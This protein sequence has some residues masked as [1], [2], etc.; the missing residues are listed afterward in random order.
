MV[1]MGIMQLPVGRLI[2]WH[3]RTGV[4]SHYA[5]MNRILPTV[6]LCEDILCF[7]NSSVI[8]MQS[9]VIWTLPW[10]HCLCFWG[11]HFISPCKREDVLFLNGAQT[12]LST[13]ISDFREDWV[14]SLFSDHAVRILDW[15]ISGNPQDTD[16][17]C[18]QDWS[19]Q[20]SP[21]LPFFIACCA[22][23]S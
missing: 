14:H 18:Q 13:L 10:I 8:P 7:G 2:T 23:P 4:T 17:M 22:V 20:E 12:N 19:N 21:S 11:K 1:A 15:Q 9:I 5:C 16:R 3:I 6:W